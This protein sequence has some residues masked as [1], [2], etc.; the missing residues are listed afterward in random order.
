MSRLAAA[1]SPLRL[2]GAVYGNTDGRLLAAHGH[3][4]RKARDARRPN[5][6]RGLLVSQRR[7]EAEEPGH[8]GDRLP[9]PT[10]PCFQKG[11]T[12]VLAELP[13]GRDQ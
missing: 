8:R 6:V 10:W 12:K 3:N 13:E 5:G 2:C 11:S 4:A 9:A 1:S 7:P